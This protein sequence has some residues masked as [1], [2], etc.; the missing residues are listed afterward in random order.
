[1]EFDIS[2]AQWSLHRT[3]RAGKLDNLDFAKTAKSE[4]GISA[5]EYVNSFFKEHAQDAAYLSEMKKRAEGEGVKSLLIMVDGEGALGDADEKRRTQAIDQHKKWL[6]AARTLGCHSIRVNAQSSG[7]W[8]EQRDR[9]ADGLHRLSLLGDQ[10]GL[11]VIVENHGGL[12]SNG[13]WLAE[14]IRRAD[15]PRC[16]TL[17]DFG[18]FRVRDDEWYDRYVGMSDLLPYAKAVSAKS[19]SF[20]ADGRE[21]Q[22]DFVRVVGLCRTHGYRGFIGIEY[23][24]ST[25]SEHEGIMLT[26][27]LLLRTFESLGSK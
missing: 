16:G 23:E 6:D 24:G 26:K 20:D 22:T 8:D 15:H 10:A 21:T 18:N 12:S 13:R 9:A 5:I 2:L 27:A 4:F 14:T 7:T 19:H 1:M 3:L 11:N 17:P 25:H